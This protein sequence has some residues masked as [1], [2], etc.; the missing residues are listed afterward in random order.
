M[1]L[2]FKVETY[3]SAH[4]VHHCI[5]LSLLVSQH[6]I[7]S[8]LIQSLYYCLFIILST[9]NLDYTAYIKELN[10]LHAYDPK[11]KPCNGHLYLPPLEVSVYLLMIRLHLIFK[12][13]IY[14]F[15]RLG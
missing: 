15:D 6:H 12:T 8:Q 7:I 10:K 9:M 2:L 1:C 13:L 14:F 5:V 11:K 3:Y 4:Y